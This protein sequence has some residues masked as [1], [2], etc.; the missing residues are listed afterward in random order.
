MYIHKNVGKKVIKSFRGILCGLGYWLVFTESLFVPFTFVPHSCTLTFSCKTP[1]DMVSVEKITKFNWSKNIY[2]AENIFASSGNPK[3]NILRPKC[4]GKS[5]YKCMSHVLQKCF[6]TFWE[7]LALNSGKKMYLWKE[8]Y[9]QHI[10]IY[11]TKWD[12]ISQIC[13]ILSNF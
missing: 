6:W 8:R 2:T 3:D 10:T 12:G 4:L 5:I 9:E 7:S 13:T 11:I 1:Y